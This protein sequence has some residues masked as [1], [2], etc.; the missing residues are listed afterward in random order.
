M[1][2][3]LY[4]SEYMR[5]KN[6]NV[7]EY[8]QPYYKNH[9]RCLDLGCGSCRKIVNLCDKVTSY[10][11]MDYDE[12]RILDAKKQCEEKGISNIILGVGDNF[13]LPFECNTF[14]LVSCFMSRYSTS[15]AARVLKKDGIFIIE[16]AGANDKRNI[17]KAFGTDNFGWRGRMLNDTPQEKVARLEGEL[18][19]FFSIVDMHIVEFETKISSGVFIELLHMTN[20]IRCFNEKIDKHIIKTLED[21]DGNIVLEEEKIIIVARKCDM[22]VHSKALVIEHR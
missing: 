13:Y 20:E 4:D 10:H 9:Y 6:Y 5:N 15:E 14:D 8:I 22:P 21:N 1:Y 17:K 16:T 7:I 12:R 3:Q 2:T 11:A 18:M 19:P